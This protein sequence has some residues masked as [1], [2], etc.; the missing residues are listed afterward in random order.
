MDE[1]H[2]DIKPRRVAFDWSR[3][4]LHWVADDPVAVHVL[5]SVHL[6]FPPGERWFVQVFKELLP[7]V[8]D[9]RLRAEMKG[10]MGQEAVH[11][12]SHEHVVKQLL[13]R[14]GIATT[15]GYRL[16]EK[17]VASRPRRRRR[18]PPRLARRVLVFE[19]AMIA[20]IEHYT[21]FLGDWML[22]A[23][24][25]DSADPTMLDLFRWHSAEEVEHRSVAFDAFQHVSGSHA[26]RTVTWALALTGLYVAII[27][28][29]VRMYNQDPAAPGR[30]NPVRLLRR[31]RRSAALGH[32]P[33]PASLLREAP[34]YL[35]RTYHPSRSCNTAQALTYLASSPAARAS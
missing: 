8:T 1:R 13:E 30:T 24:G 5:N 6:L 18:L 16:A 3:T 21:A 34:V 29:A 9:E 32:I 20:A 27:D 23:E 10:F 35:S 14:E 25:L 4:P 11:A 17:I 33:H 28:G 26:L 22:N 31:M 7:L 2:P 12:Y 15:P 19:A